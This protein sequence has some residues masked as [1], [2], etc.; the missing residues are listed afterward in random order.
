MTAMAG[1]PQPEHYRT[2]AEYSWA[3]RNWRRS[4]GGGLLAKLAI[5]VVFGAWSGSQ[6]ALWGLVGF[7]IVT[8]LI[9]RSRP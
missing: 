6:A 7:A 4:H 8:H 2:R 1:R 5:A 3:R 9:A